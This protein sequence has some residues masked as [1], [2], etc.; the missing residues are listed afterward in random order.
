MTIE[1]SFKNI[2]K[3]KIV[4]LKD[5]KAYSVKELWDRVVKP[6]LL[7][8][9]VVEKWFEEVKKYVN[10]PM[11]CSLFELAILVKTATPLN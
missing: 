5:G 9:S 4:P 11:R 1:D 10:D 7:P 2:N 3:K 8:K 6:L